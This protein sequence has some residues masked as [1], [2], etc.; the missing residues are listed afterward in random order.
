VTTPGDSLIEHPPSH[1]LSNAD[2]SESHPAFL[3]IALIPTLNS[4][5]GSGAPSALLVPSP[6]GQNPLSAESQPV[7][8]P[9]RAVFCR[10]Y[11]APW[12]STKTPRAGLARRG[13]GARL[14]NP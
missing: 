6:L 4:L 5:T 9:L 10:L 1:M 14:G 2:Y 8:E 12:A 13:L 11:R 3:A 7:L